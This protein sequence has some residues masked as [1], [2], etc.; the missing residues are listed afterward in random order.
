MSAAFDDYWSTIE[1]RNGWTPDTVLE[2]KVAGLRKLVEQA[3]SKGFE[4]GAKRR[5][6]M[7]DIFR[8]A[9]LHL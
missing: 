7:D 4:S 5:E 1:K 8:K 3:Y 2:V 6:A 9:G